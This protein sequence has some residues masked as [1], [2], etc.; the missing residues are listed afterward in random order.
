MSTRNIV[1]N[2]AN[3]LAIRDLL[4]RYTNAVNQRT[5]SVIETLFSRDAVWDA[6]GPEMGDH[7]FRFEGAANIGHGIASL[8]SATELCVQSNHAVVVEIDGARA[9]ATSTINEMV[10]VKDAPGVM[11]NWGTYY[12]DIV[13]ESAGEWRFRQRVFRFTWTDTSGPRGQVIARFPR[14]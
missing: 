5:W 9:T 14:K 6:G 8:V 2:A 12:D 13:R 7:A 11:N 3:H 4:D 1:E 10:L